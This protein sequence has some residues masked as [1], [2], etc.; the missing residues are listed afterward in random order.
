[1]SGGSGGSGG[2]ADPGG[3]SGQGGTPQ[4]QGAD[5]PECDFT[6]VWIANQMT[7]S[8]ALGLWQ[9]SNNWFYLELQQT[10][11]TVVVT[12]SLDCGIEVL[13]TATVTLSRKT[14]EAS[15]LRNPQ[16][17]HQATV[18]KLDGKCT[19]ET[20]RFWKVRG[21]DEQR[22]LP[23]ETRDS[24][25]SVAKVAMDKP[26]PTSRMTDGAV[27]TEG[28]G[29]L[30]MA[31]Q[32]TGVISGVRN[33]VQRDWSRWFTEPGF[34]IAASR[35]WASD[36][37]IRADFDNEESILDPTSGLLAA[38]AQPARGAKHRAKLRFLGR[39]RSDLRAAAF[40]KATEIDTCYAIQDAMKAEVVE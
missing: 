2:S 14:L 9:T 17:G 20:A 29:K 18:Q 1:M 31:F 38:T 22:F 12:K 30:G 3:S 39:D 11:S 16:N 23:N 37:I 25:D 21:A 27:D 24:M 15:L 34:E 10:G 28:D 35:D 32:L 6:G 19:F 7:V 4:P 26:L 8:E 33:S 36:L 40:V 5:D 13:G